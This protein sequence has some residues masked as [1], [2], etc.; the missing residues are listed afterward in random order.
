MKIKNLLAGLFAL[1]YA[2]VFIYA[3]PIEDGKLLFMARC[4]G[5]HTITTTL[6]G[7]ALAGVDK[8]RSMEWI[9]QFVHSSQ[10]LVKSGD[11][12]AIGIFNQFNKVPMPDHQD[13]TEDNIKSIIEYIKAEEVS[14]NAKPKVFKH[15]RLQTLYMPL[16]LSKD[17]GIILIYLLAVALL[18]AVLLFVVRLKSIQ[19]TAE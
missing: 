8:R 12:D 17:Y 1:L 14:F 19:H 18:I 2:P 16:S 11:K 4:A 7:P 10:T 5:C 3:D 15:G 13:L 9:V 6:T